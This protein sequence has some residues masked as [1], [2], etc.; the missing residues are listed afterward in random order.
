E[1]AGKRV[2]VRVDFNVPQDKS[3]KITDDTRIV[4]ALPTVKTLVERG[5]KVILVSHLGR[6][7]G[8]TPEF[9]L[10]PA[11]ARLSELLGKNVP[12][13]PDCVGEAVK[14]RVNAMQNGDV[15]LLEN[16]RFHPEEEK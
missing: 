12:L 9:T 7:K 15:V 2:L 5:A 1:V 10:A 8:V 13:L 3:G 14:A 11:A 4:A 6:P 16:V